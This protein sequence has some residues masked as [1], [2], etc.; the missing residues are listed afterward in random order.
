MGAEG[1]VWEDRKIPGVYWPV[2]L[3]KRVKFNLNESLSQENKTDS[4][5]GRHQ[6][7]S[8]LL[9]THKPIRHMPLP[10][11]YKKTPE[12]KYIE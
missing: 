9:Y 1:T 10:H 11:T 12:L 2:K 7:S 6:I 8:S 3:A 5:R 4:N